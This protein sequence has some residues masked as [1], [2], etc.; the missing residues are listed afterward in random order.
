MPTAVKRARG[1]PGKRALPVDEPDP[2]PATL[3][4]VP[5]W[6]QDKA[7]KHWGVIGDALVEM[8]VLSVMDTTAL[9]MFCEV[10]AQYLDARD[11]TMKIKSMVYTTATGSLKIRPEFGHMHQC[12]DRLFRILQEYGCT[13]SSRTRVRVLK[14][15][16]DKVNKFEAM[17]KAGLPGPTH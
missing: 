11:A 1:N 12:H 3:Q 5:R 6:V 4:D 10:F 17:K 7:G 15:K 13:P 14:T 9:G 2:V 16:Q 8:G